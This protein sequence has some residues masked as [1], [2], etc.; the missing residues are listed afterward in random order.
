MRIHVTKT[1]LGSPD[2][3]EVV[4]F[5]AGTRHTMPDEL[6][7]VFLREGWG[8]EA[9]AEELD[10]E[11]DAPEGNVDGASDPEGQLPDSAPA[12]AKPAAKAKGGK[13]AP[14]KKGGK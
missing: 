14:A 8:E 1:Q 9:E 4:K 7:Q 11:E 5:Q 13:K 12:V 2:G 6:A 10:E 3:I